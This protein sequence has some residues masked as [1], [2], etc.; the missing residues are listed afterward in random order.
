MKKDKEFLKL[1]MNGNQTINGYLS[2]DK[3]FKNIIDEKG[4]NIF[5]YLIAGNQYKLTE[6]LIENKLISYF[7]LKKTINSLLDNQSYKNDNYYNFFNLLKEEDKEKIIKKNL[8]NIIKNNNIKTVN[9]VS[10][11][12]VIKEVKKFKINFNTFTQC[13][14]EMLE[15][16]IEIYKNSDFNIMDLKDG[17]YKL[18]LNKI[19]TSVLMENL[20]INI[21][22]LLYEELNIVNEYCVLYLENRDLY[23]KLE[24]NLKTKETKK[25]KKI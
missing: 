9:E 4:N 7:L 17:F 15:I 25:F 2:K 16:C 22:P 13:N 5:H 8:E 1:A 11:E 14:D 21:S 20:N 12:K 23:N 18:K 24:K 3:Q 6:N 19:R 10:I